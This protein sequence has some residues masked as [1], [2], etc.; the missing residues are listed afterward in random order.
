ML[1][2]VVWLVVVAVAVL[3]MGPTDR[4]VVAVAG[5][6]AAA[7]T[8]GIMSWAEHARWH[9]PIRDVANFASAL[10]V[11]RK[12]RPESAPPADLLELTRE[13]ATL[14]KS[15]RLRAIPERP[16]LGISANHQAGQPPPLSTASLTRSG[17]FDSPPQE[18][19]RQIDPNMS[20][21]F[22]TIDM[23]NRLEPVG[24][25]WMESSPAEQDFLGWTLTELRAK[26]FL[27]VLHPDDR[28]R[29]EEN[30][31]QALARG[32]ALGLVVRVRTG[33]GKTRAVEVNVVRVTGPIRRS[34]ISV[35]IS[36]T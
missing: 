11:N 26:S 6:V 15:L 29:T 34:A 2:S 24:F 16:A 7:L 32:E 28:D 5:L 31:Q 3:K 1:I 19:S 33:H 9:E 27:D 22:S 36:P 35:V 4:I 21:D 25:H 10:R 8:F 17:L 20:G 12:A 13:I 18:A 14:A 23:V 30:F